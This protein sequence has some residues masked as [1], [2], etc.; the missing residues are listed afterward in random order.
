[1][2]NTVNLTKQTVNL[3]KGQSINLSKTTDI[4]LKSVLIGLGWEP[5]KHGI[6]ERIAAAFGM[7]KFEYDLD[8]YVVALGKDSD[9]EVV[10]YNNLTWS[11]KGKMYIQHHGDN[12]TG[13]G[14]AADKEQ[15]SIN[16][17]DIPNTYDEL[18]IGV[19]I[20]EARRRE[21]CFGNVHGMFI[22]VVDQSNNFEVCRYADEMNQMPDA[23]T[24]IAGK[25]IRRNSEWM[26]E[27]VGEPTVEGSISEVVARVSKR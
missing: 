20:Y 13:H 9:I 2:E 6:F 4:G 10:Y 8:A 19:T 5:V 18:V 7:G 27:A 17:A 15:I 21:Q 24:F 23:T 16:L 1:M 12:L 3:S 25:L 14:K 26:F 11:G 22:R